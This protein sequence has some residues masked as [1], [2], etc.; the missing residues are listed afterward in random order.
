[1]ELGIGCP[2]SSKG[3][4]L[5]WMQRVYRQTAFAGLPYAFILRL[6]RLNTPLSYSDS[7]AWRLDQN[8]QQPAP[9]EE[10]H[11]FCDFPSRQ[12]AD[13]Y[14]TLQDAIALS[15]VAKR[16]GDSFEGETQGENRPDRVLAT[17]LCTTLRHLTGFPE[18]W[19]CFVRSRRFDK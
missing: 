3:G 17:A 8:A 14:L 5:G 4:F 19:R 7:K 9:G 10:R 2:T 1:M 18:G 12:T 13:R 11:L 16:A 15:P 6:D